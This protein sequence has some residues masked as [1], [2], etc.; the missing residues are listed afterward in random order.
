MKRGCL[1]FILVGV[2]LFSMSM[3]VL[4]IVIGG[5]MDAFDP[6]ARVDLAQQYGNDHAVMIRIDPNAANFAGVAGE[7][8]EADSWLVNW[9]LPHEVL[10]FLDADP[11]QKKV[12]FTAAVSTRHFGGLLS[13]YIPFVSDWDTGTGFEIRGAQVRTDGVFIANA[14]RPLLDE[15]LHDAERRWDSK[16]SEPLE[17]EKTH[18]LEVLVN[19]G[20]GAAFLALQSFITVEE[21][22]REAEKV[23]LDEEAMR[24][25]TLDVSNTRMTANFE[26]GD[27]CV[28]TFDA[29]C[30]NKKS[31]KRALEAFITLEGNFREAFKEDGLELLGKFNAEDTSIRGEFRID[32]IH[33]SLRESWHDMRH[34][35]R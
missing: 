34:Q 27:N 32:N 4:I 7:T 26:A 20:A 22:Q 17:F 13:Y 31:T 18:M 15:T 21:G 9:F 33:A 35:R 23:H 2:L 29:T 28:F 6:A 25:L 16:E 14:E 19:N 8:I 1:L 10:L 11:E 24:T 12:F 3:V 5:M 30:P